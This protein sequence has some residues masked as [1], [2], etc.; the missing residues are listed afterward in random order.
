MPKVDSEHYLPVES[1]AEALET[2]VR[3]IGR[4]LR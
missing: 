1:Y 3:G 4:A 2:T